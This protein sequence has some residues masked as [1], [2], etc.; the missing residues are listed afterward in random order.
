MSGL[1]YSFW[2]FCGVG[3]MMTEGREEE[4]I[5]SPRDTLR[6][7][8]AILALSR[9]RSVTASRGFTGRFTWHIHLIETSK[10]FY[11]RTS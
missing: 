10:S 6:E 5:V 3:G 8:P 7:I 4:V 11:V 2:M 9:G 1:D